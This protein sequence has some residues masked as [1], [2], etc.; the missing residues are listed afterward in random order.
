MDTTKSS[1]KTQQITI[2]F[3]PEQMEILTQLSI[4]EGMTKPEYIRALIFNQPLDHRNIILHDQSGILKNLRK[5]SDA[6]ESLHRIEKTLEEQSYRKMGV[7]S[8]IY[9][10]VRSLQDVQWELS[11]AINQEY[12]YE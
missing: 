5:I 12:R 4:G 9:Y 6:V 8:N 1:A 7:M 10:L 3:S 2:R 11:E